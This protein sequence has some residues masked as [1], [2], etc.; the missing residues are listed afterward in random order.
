[1][2]TQD[3][4]LTAWRLATHNRAVHAGLIFH[5]DRG[6][7]YA[8]NKFVNVL[9]SCKKLLKVC[10]EKANAV[11]ESFFKLLKTELIYGP[12]LITKYK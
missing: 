11:A 4:I 3:T 5:S 2:S 10:P 1:M 9:N 7:Q 12:K 6:T 8:N